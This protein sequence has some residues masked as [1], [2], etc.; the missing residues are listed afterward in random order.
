M[1][2]RFD[3]IIWAIILLTPV[4]AIA[5][6]LA[7]WLMPARA[8][9]VS[10]IAS[11]L[12][13]G[14]TFELAWV[15]I[16]QI[17]QVNRQRSA[18]EEASF[19]P[20]L[21]P[22][23]AVPP[24]SLWNGP[25]FQLHIKN[26][27]PGLA[28]NV[29]AVLLPPKADRKVIPPLFYATVPGPIPAGESLPIDLHLGGYMIAEED[30]ISGVSMAVPPE[31]MPEAGI[32]DMRRTEPRCTARLTITASDL[33]G[34]KHASFFDWPTS[35]GWLAVKLVPHATADIGEIDAKRRGR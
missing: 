33:I 26:V 29:E 17:R 10:P 23:G 32:P 7:T 5:I 1:N 22:D 20:V 24:E 19:R 35:G 31:R 12:V 3:K 21:I 25:G 30:S 13:A 8:S 2:T 15:A 27:G 11:I 34:V 16:L 14:G 6:A 9:L 4:S 28:F 18:Q